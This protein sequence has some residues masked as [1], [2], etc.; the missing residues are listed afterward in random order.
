MLTGVLIFICPSV[1]FCGVIL[2][3]LVEIQKK[4]NRYRRR[5]PGAQFHGCAASP[6]S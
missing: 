3:L 4:I 1:L 2:A 6:C 5:P